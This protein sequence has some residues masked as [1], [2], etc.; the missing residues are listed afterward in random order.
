M[1]KFQ[2]HFVEKKMMDKKKFKDWYSGDL[3]ATVTQNDLISC[4][5]WN[6]KN[7]HKMNCIRLVCAGIECNQNEL[8]SVRYKIH[9]CTKKNDIYWVYRLND[10]NDDIE[11]INKKVYGIAL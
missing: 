8:C 1:V 9:R 4:T 7:S 6:G 5:C 2:W 10:H 3:A 11:V